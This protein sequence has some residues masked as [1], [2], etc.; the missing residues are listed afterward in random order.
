[1]EQ[2][3]FK[4]MPYTR[5]SKDEIL[6]SLAAFS[7]RAEE[8]ESFS[9]LEK[10]LEEYSSY[11]NEINT[12]GTLSF[13]RFTQNTQDEFYVKENDFWDEVSPEINFSVTKF[14]EIIYNS[15]FRKELEEIFTPV[16][17]D[18]IKLSLSV[19]DERLIPLEVETAK[20]V[21]NYTKL[22]SGLVVDFNGEK[23]PPSGI[24]KY[25]T[26]P[27]REL[28]EGAYTALGKK[29]MEVADQLDEI[30]DNLVKM[31][32][33]QANTIGQDVFSP[34]GYAHMLRTCYTKE[35]IAKFRSNVKKYFVPLVSKIKHHVQA[36]LGLDRIAFYDDSIYSLKN[37][38]PYGD[39]SEMFKNAEE[40]YDEMAPE[41][42]SLFRR[43]EAMETFD[44]ESRP[45]KWGG[46]YQ[47][48]LP[49]Y[50]IPFI[51]GN[52]NGSCDDIGT[53]THEFGHALNASF[54]M[55][56][57]FASLL[58]LTMETAECHSMGMEFMTYP[59]MDKFFKDRLDDY[60]FTH[61]AGAIAFIP[62]GTIVDAFQQYIYDNPNL[63]PQERIEYWKELE[64]EFLPY[65]D[66]SNIPFYGDGRR[67]QRQ[68]HIFESPFYYIDYCLAQFTAFQFLAESVK[69]YDKALEK[70][71]N[72]SKLGPTRS[73]TELIELSGLKSPFE[74][75]SFKDIVKTVEELL[76]L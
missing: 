54:N 18:R 40:M 70:Y 20:M 63:T 35:D 53:F 39:F 61:I 38:N 10:V 11:I 13:I 6:A 41:A 60:K 51:L 1:M 22:M 5:P 58:T 43:M 59:W 28:R 48:E 7:K 68:A 37:T 31:R 73:F 32:T 9:E 71:L 67:W 14:Q 56:R 76:G 33:K 2:I 64:R 55:Q 50:G 52:F 8:A 72:F 26:N 15:K 19:S 24:A 16:F 74:E 75:D 27:N 23:L 66:N 12:L 25:A 45:G 42:S 65:M 17:F 34:L 69:D 29:Y 57:K 44:I 21:S 62:Y 36:D 4:D 49:K 47:T 30:F 3:K 46:G